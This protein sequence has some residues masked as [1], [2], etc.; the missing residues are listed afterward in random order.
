M[1]KFVTS[2][3]LEIEAFEAQMFTRAVEQISFQIKDIKSEKEAYEEYKSL[4]S[5]YIQ[6][7]IFATFY[8]LH[9][10]KETSSSYINLVES[11]KSD[12]PNR[13]AEIEWA[14]IMRSRIVLAVQ[15]DTFLFD[16]DSEGYTQIYE[17]KCNEHIRAILDHIKL[18]I[19][20][21]HS[22]VSSQV[23]ENW[24]KSQTVV[25]ITLSS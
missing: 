9:L 14:D 12:N 23:R 2:Y 17:K 5:Q 15:F 25:K 22:A 20:N 4:Y 7:T 19:S 24:K 13:I 21:N 6:D 8:I 11:F 1:S 16:K 10:S 3:L 18:A